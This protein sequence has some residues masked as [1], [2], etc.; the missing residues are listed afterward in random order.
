MKTK[1]LKKISRTFRNAVAAGNG[2]GSFPVPETSKALSDLT[3]IVNT[4]RDY[5][6]VLNNIE[7][8]ES[9]LRESLESDFR[10]LVEQELDETGSESGVERTLQLLLLPGS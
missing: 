10:E 2:S 5:K 7:E 8:A 1:G 3:D 9:L 4:Y 6:Q